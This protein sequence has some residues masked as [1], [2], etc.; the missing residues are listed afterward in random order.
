MSDGTRVIQ[1]VVLVSRSVSTGLDLAVLGSL[2]ATLRDMPGTRAWIALA[3]VATVSASVASGASGDRLQAVRS[4]ATSIRPLGGGRLSAGLLRSGQL[5]FQ[6]LDDR[7]PPL[8]PIGSDSTG[9]FFVVVWNLAVAERDPQLV[10]ITSPQARLAFR[11]AEFGSKAIRRSATDASVEFK[12]CTTR[13]LTIF[14]GGI[15]LFDHARCVRLAITDLRTH[16][17]TH[18]QLGVGLTCP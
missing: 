13:K 16:H 9:K 18:A 7:G 11:V 15:V 10:A 6:S 3:L 8:D 14:N 5:L 1:P 17:T 2:R 4:C 12:P